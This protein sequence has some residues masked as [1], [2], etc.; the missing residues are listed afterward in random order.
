MT[1]IADLSGRAF[2]NIDA[3][4]DTARVVTYLE[5]ASAH[6]RGLKRLSY[7]SLSLQPGAVVL[8]VGCGTGDD[9]RELAKLVGSRGR[10]V[11]IDSSESLIIEARRRGESGAPRPEF[12]IAEADRIELPADTFDACRADRVLQHLVDPLAALAEMVRVCKPGGIVEVVDRDW[13][14]V[15]VDAD[16]QTVTRAILERICRG[17]QNG[18]I[19]RQLPT[20]FHDAG[21]RYVRTRAHPI[22]LRDFRSADALL[23]LTIVAG[24]AVN[25]GLVSVGQATAWLQELHA[26]NRAGRFF[27]ALVMF[28]VTG[29]KPRRA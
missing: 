28:V 24:H 20:L 3:V 6:F 4:G 8:D 21:L 14:L 2:G 13:S 25:E 10:V 7:R 9:A 27:A 29:R 26:R 11:G 23:D 15:A 17:I 12:L 22:A 1:S 16:D 18:W 19:G 5:T